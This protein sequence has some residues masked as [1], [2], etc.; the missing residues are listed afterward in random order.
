MELAATSPG[1]SGPGSCSPAGLR[2]PRPSGGGHA[3]C[4]GCALA[5]AGYLR[6]QTASKRVVEGILLHCAAGGWSGLAALG[7]GFSGC[8]LDDTG[9]TWCWGRLMA[10]NGSWANYAT[11]QPLPGNRTWIQLA[12]G[13]AVGC[14]VQEG[15]GKAYCWGDNSTGL[16]L[17]SGGRN[18]SAEPLPLA[19]GW[20]PW[21]RLS[22][23]SDSACGVLANGSAYCWVSC[24]CT[25]H[26]AF[27]LPALLRCHAV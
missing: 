18:Y 5:A 25:V 14:G 6:S 24:L 17:G 26:A 2:L 4:A 9:A 20:G 22:I 12:V 21:Q 27:V 16:L 19:P 10:D 1:L 3:R 8:A 15:D 23:G 11:P 13:D 7:P